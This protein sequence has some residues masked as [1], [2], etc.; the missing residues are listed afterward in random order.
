MT[1]KDYYEILGIASQASPEEIKKAFRQRALQYHPDRNPGDKA[2]EEHFKEAAEAYS[3]L[4]DPEKRS[5]YDRYG[6]A[7]LKGEG[8]S[9]FTGFDSSIFGDFEDILGNFFGFSFGDFFGSG[10]EA[11]RRGPQRGRDLALEVEVTL[12]EAAKGVEKELSLNRVDLCAACR[13]SGLKPGT[14]KAVCSTC[15][16]QGQV[17]YQQG[18]FTIAR[19]CPD[20]GGPGEVITTPCPDC[21]GTGHA[22]GKKSLTI[23]IP[24]GIEDQSRLRLSGEGEAGGA[25]AP[26]GDLF[27]VVRVRP[28]E[29]FER[30][31]NDLVCEVVVSFAQAALGVSVAIPA[32]SG[33]EVLKI[34]PGTQSEDILR[35]K[36]KGLRDLRTQRTGDIYV[37]V[38]VKTPEHLSKEEKDLLRGLAAAREEELEG[39]IK[40][41]LHKPDRKVH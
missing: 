17:R 15:K 30:E 6:L 39:L 7:G 22:K 2:C 38:L 8:Y 29:L 13:G 19:T 9:G 26:R 21:R 23:K 31:R 4:G 37:K 10:T 16:G 32:L 20:C 34:P 27:V 11:R 14:K 35:I 36:G 12:E 18:F 1:R 24:A 5:I 41:A 28:H 3:V 40:N 33:E 25:D